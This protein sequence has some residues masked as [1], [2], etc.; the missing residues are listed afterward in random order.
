MIYIFYESTTQVFFFFTLRAWRF[1]SLS[2]QA[3]ES[4]P[5]TSLQQYLSETRKNEGCGNLSRQAKPSQA[6]RP[7]QTGPAKNTQPSLVN[8]LD[9][10]AETCRNN[11]VGVV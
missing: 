11:V 8:K 6:T 3:N 4:L 1:D 5:H 7:H 9:K 2:P 10:H